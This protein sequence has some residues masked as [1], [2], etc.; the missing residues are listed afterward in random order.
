MKISNYVVVLTYKSNPHEPVIEFVQSH[1]KDNVIVLAMRNAGYSDEEIDY[2]V[3]DKGSQR[4]FGY[5][6]DVQYTVREI[7]ITNFVMDPTNLT[8]DGKPENE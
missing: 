3:N 5:M 7:L 6:D 2:L 4:T 8:V 1:E